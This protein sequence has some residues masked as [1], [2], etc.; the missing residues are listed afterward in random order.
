MIEKTVKEM[1]D[2]VLKMQESIN[3]DIEDI[4]AARNE[5][6]LERNDEKQSMMDQIAALKQ[7]LN[8]L[9]VEAIQNGEDVDKYREKVDSLEDE[10]RT[11]YKLN[12][13]LASIVLPIQQMYKE[14]VDELT[15]QSGGNIIELK[16]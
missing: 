1:H 6:L 14:I 16:A 5:K 12:A 7:N 13:K 15:A 8:G 3:L 11:L 2:L 9:L 10:L 4:K